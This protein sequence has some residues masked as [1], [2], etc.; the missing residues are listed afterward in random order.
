[1]TI[2]WLNDYSEQFLSKD[3]LLPGQTV[4]ERLKIIGDYAEAILKRDAKTEEHK[5]Y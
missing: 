4:Q 2:R 3:Y 1:M 5:Q